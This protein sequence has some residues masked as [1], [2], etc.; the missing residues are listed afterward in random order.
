MRV[1]MASSVLPICQPQDLWHVEYA[2][3]EA[4]RPFVRRILQ[5][6]SIRHGRHIIRV[7]PSGATYLTY[8]YGAAEVFRFGDEP[9]QLAPPLF[10]GGQLKRYMPVAEVRGDVGLV[11][12]EFT[13]TGLFRLFHQDCSVLADRITPFADL[14]PR[15]A[16]RLSE[17]L[18][19]SRN[20]DDRIAVF[21][22]LLRERV[23][24]AADAADVEQALALIQ[25][26]DGRISVQALALQC[27]TSSRQLNRRF[28]KKVGVSPKHF[29]KVVQVK[30]TIQALQAAD[31]GTLQDIAQ[32][33]GYYDQAHFIRDVQRLVGTN[34]MAFLRTRDPF[35]EM[36]LRR[37]KGQ[38]V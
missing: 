4:L 22:S 16:R 28:L 37:H 11:G 20:S 3:S 1:K 6:D 23:D 32:R 21:D 5:T 24:A 19:A 33:A 30:T 10:V 25:Q 14:L 2:P 29:A 31:R 7:P 36:Y 8:V 34:P 12:V 38:G 15:L 27:R 35:L 13:P 17:R 18:A 26:H 9:P